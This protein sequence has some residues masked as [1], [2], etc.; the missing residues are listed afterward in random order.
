E[1]LYIDPT[2]GQQRAVAT[3]EKT[4][5]QLFGKI[6][7]ATLCL[8]GSAFPFPFTVSGQNEIIGGTGKYTGATGTGEVHSAGSFLIFG[9]KDG[10]FGALG[11]FTF[12]S[13]GTLTLPN[14]HED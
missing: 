12:T 2:H 11:Q 3:D 5:D 10:V 1:E 7:S 9:V 14:D 8:N 4:G 13:D 6:T